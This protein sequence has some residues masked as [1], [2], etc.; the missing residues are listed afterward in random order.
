VAFLAIAPATGLPVEMD[1]R[2]A[3]LREI[4]DEG[5]RR[6]NMAVIGRL[7]LCVEAAQKFCFPAAESDRTPSMLR[8]PRPGR[9]RSPS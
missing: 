2:T 7:L 4:R 9:H 8:L 1:L 5:H 6:I 3:T